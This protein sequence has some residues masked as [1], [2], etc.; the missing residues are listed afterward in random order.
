M[1]ENEP[2]DLLLCRVNNL[3]DELRELREEIELTVRLADID[4]R[5]TLTRTRRVLENVVTDVFQR[6]LHEDPGTRP[7]EN[8]LQRLVKEH[9]MPPR[10]AAYANGIRDLG[11][12]GTHGRGET[13]SKADAHHSLSQLVVI[14]LWYFETER[15]EA[16]RQS[17]KAKSPEV[18]IREKLT[19][20]E[21]GPAQVKV[22]D[23]IK[24]SVEEPRPPW[25]L[26]WVGILAVL[27]LCI[28]LAMVLR[29]VWRTSLTE[30]KPSAHPAAPQPIHKE[31]PSQAQAGMPPPP[32]TASE[33]AVPPAKQLDPVLPQTAVP[34]PYRG[35]S[36]DCK[37]AMTF[38]E[39]RICD[40]PDLA[41]ADLR[42]NA[43]YEAARRALSASAAAQLKQE[44]LAWLK[45]RDA[46]LM[47]KCTANQQFDAACAASF[48]NRRVDVLSALAH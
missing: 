2:L 25:P 41:E 11:N 9:F 24:E 12:L 40:Y 6:H 36:F 5:M 44:Q 34:Y 48:L 35:P 1:Q 10:I 22:K 23:G 37:K 28:V 7:L 17:E 18:E 42:L 20:E 29:P 4:P 30:N 16:I 8:L 26:K 32:M 38:V 13:I 3:T 31:P 39:H 45:E 27:G 47:R 15:P 33:N 19:S 43:A 14:L 46:F 21:N